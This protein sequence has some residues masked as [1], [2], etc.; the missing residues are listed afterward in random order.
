[1]GARNSQCLIMLILAPKEMDL[2]LKRMSLLNLR[3]FLGQKT[4]VR[5][6]FLDHLTR[7]WGKIKMTRARV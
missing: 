3:V 2:G 1:L 5:M 4:E 7:E 6:T